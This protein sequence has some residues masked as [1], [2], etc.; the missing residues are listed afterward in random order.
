MP[1]PYSQSPGEVWRPMP[2]GL[3]LLALFMAGVEIVFQLADGGIFLDASLRPRVYM[4]GAFWGG[5]LYDM[6]PIFA[7]QPVTMFVSHA[8]LHGGL[9]HLAMNLAVLLG[10]GRFVADRYGDATVLPLFLLSAIAGGLVF[11]LINTEDIPM[12]GASGAVFGFLGVWTV[13]DWRRHRAH[14]VSVRPVAMRAL[15]LV[16]INVVLF[17]GLGGMLAWEAHLG[18]YLAGLVFGAWLERAL[19]AAALRA[20]AEARRAGRAPGDL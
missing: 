8:L 1:D 4:V 10:L 13:W 12:V 6:T 14:G 11:G 5:L 9:L 3:V 19:A 20:R 15:G 2:R 17:F 7:L 16:L 18:G